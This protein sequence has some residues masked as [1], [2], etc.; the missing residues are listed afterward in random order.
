MLLAYAVNAPDA[1]LYLRRVP[2]QVGMMGS[3]ASV[4]RPLAASLQRRT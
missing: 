3:A 1:L 4:L 2:W